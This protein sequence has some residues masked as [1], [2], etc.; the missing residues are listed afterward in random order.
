MTYKLIN[1][2]MKQ[3]FP[4][5]NWEVQ[6]AREIRLE[7]GLQQSIISIISLSPLGHAHEGILYSLKVVSISW[8]QLATGW[9]GWITGITINPTSKIGNFI[10]F[11]MILM[12]YAEKCVWTRVYTRKSLG[13][14]AYGIWNTVFYEFLSKSMGM[15][16]QGHKNNHESHKGEKWCYNTYNIG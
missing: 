9:G 16:A 7:L 1:I 8:K 3:G 11:L 4:V 6:E 10:Y 14:P 5:I 2:S 12:E 13:I 15:G